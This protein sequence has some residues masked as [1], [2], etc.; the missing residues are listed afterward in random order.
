M[1]FKGDFATIVDV[2]SD[3]FTMNKKM[4]VDEYYGQKSQQWSCAKDPFP[5]QEGGAILLTGV[6]GKIVLVVF[7][8]MDKAKF[9]SL[10]L[11]CLLAGFL[12]KLPGKMLWPQHQ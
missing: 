11:L 2:I 12:K 3:L 8:C 10:T 6:Y 5:P 9:F 4:G 1:K 7:R